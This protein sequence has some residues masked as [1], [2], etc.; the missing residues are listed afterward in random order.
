MCLREIIDDMKLYSIQ[1]RVSEDI[2]VKLDA[3]VRQTGQSRSGVIRL[4]IDSEAEDSRLIPSIPVE[5]REKMEEAYEKVQGQYGEAVKIPLPGGRV[6]LFYI[7]PFRSICV[8]MLLDPDNKPVD[9]EELR[10]TAPIVDHIIDVLTSG[11]YDWHTPNF[12]ELCW[13][14]DV[15]PDEKR[16]KFTAEAEAVAADLHKHFHK[17]DHMNPRRHFILDLV[18]LLR[19]DLTPE[20]GMYDSVKKA[21]QN[22]SEKEKIALYDQALAL[23]DV[24]RLR[25]SKPLGTV[26]PF[27]PSWAGR[28]YNA[29]IYLWSTEDPDEDGWPKKLYRHVTG[30]ARLPVGELSITQQTVLRRLK[31]Q[32]VTFLTEEE[33]DRYMEGEGAYWR[34][35]HSVPAPSEEKLR[36]PVLD[37]ALAWVIKHVRKTPMPN[38]SPPAY[39]P[40]TPLHDAWLA[41]QNDTVH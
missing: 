15:D 7:C 24:K 13:R 19:T 36:H 33:A 10:G 26:I 21:L 22:M 9:Y 1:I 16:P 23:V 34:W 38:D 6:L 40:A 41:R 32:G 28:G 17:L 25:S 27:L 18:E 39:K 29:S 11:D 35:Y 5:K 12:R 2:L 31:Q 4:L 30:V 3:I 8:A 14:L 20:I 37:S